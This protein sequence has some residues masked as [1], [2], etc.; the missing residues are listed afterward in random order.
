[1]KSEHYLLADE[2]HTIT[3]IFLIVRHLKDVAI[4]I[5]AQLEHSNNCSR[6]YRSKS[7]KRVSQKTLDSRKK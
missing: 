5:S 1:M 7:V 3:L 2:V 6:G 4:E